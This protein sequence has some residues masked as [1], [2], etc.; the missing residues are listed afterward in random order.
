MFNETLYILLDDTTNTT[1]AGAHYLQWPTRLDA[2]Q[3]G[4]LIECVFL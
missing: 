4:V 1:H 3:V 2:A